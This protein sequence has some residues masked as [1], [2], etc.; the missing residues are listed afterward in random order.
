MNALAE[1]QKRARP[2]AN[3]A[4]AANQ[5]RQKVV[6]SQDSQDS[7]R[8]EAE[9]RL[10]A[11][12]TS[13][14]LARLADALKPL[15]ARLLALAERQAVEV[16]HVH[17]LH[18]LDVAVCAGLD[19]GELAGYLDML[20]DTA[21][22]H[23]GRVPLDDTAVMHCEGC[24]PVWIHPDIAAVLPVV[25]GWPRA[26]GCPWCFV[27]KS[28]GYIPRPPVTCEGCRHF[29]PDTINPEAGMGTCGAGKGMHWP[30]TRHTCADHSTRN[31]HDE[32]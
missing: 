9:T 17:R 4:N 23:A 11:T 20:R 14:P 31:L 18:D 13:A 28:G 30:M 25:D 1:L 19:D 10:S 5:G 26:L 29:T 2:P 21:D 24:G 27:R 16:A 15:R 3:P 8:V 12:T 7:Q 32:A 22:R 6:D